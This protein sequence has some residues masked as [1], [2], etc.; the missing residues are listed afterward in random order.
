MNKVFNYFLE[1]YTGSE[2]RLQQ[3]VKVL[4]GMDIF[5]FLLLFVLN[6]L[7]IFKMGRDL[8]NA[9]VF[10]IFIVQIVLVI[11]LLFLKKGH[12]HIAV[13]MTLGSILMAVWASFFSASAQKDM[14]TKMNTLDYVFPIIILVT[15][16]SNKRG[17][18]IYSVINSL[19]IIAL[20]QYFFYQGRLESYQMVDF[21]VDGMITYLMSAACC[22]AL[23]Y[24]NDNAHEKIHL[25]LKEN[26]NYSS[27]IKE[28]LTQTGDVAGIL[29]TSTEELASVTESFSANTQSQASSVEEMAAT[30]EEITAGGAGVHNMAQRQVDLVQQVR[31]EMEQVY[32]VADNAMKQMQNA[33]VIRGEMNDMVEKSKIEIQDTMQIMK[34]ATSRFQNVQET[35]DII[36]DISDK[37]NLLSLNA[38][39]EAARAGDQGRGFAVV[40]DEI[41][42]L[43][44][45]T[46]TNVKSINDLFLGSQA[47]MNKAY[48]TM[49]LFIETLNRMISHISSFSGMLDVVEDITRQDIAL[50]DRARES[51]GNVISEANNILSAIDVQKVAMEEVAKSLGIIN[52][53]VQKTASGSE[54]LMGTSKEVAQ[55]AQHLMALSSGAY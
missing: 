19:L 14:L 48:A 34:S 24:M 2:Y 11:S 22:F 28:I 35:V 39:I 25:A 41:G 4:V 40:A 54:E 29:A 30:V 32:T 45:N 36:R 5:I 10:G 21:I 47:E 37:I 52:E 55:S 23:L 31:K 16:V 18:I 53:S 42:K 3:K 1:K 49:E 15:I 12:Y 26:E 51:L 38:A 7:F 46:S 20:G 43:A 27:S 6:G 33:V 9:S 50:K 13:H 8:L 17:I 44:D